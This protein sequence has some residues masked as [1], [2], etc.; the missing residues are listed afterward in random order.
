M[1]RSEL[2]LIYLPTSHLVSH[3]IDEAGSF[4]NE[5]MINLWDEMRYPWSYQEQS[6]QRGPDQLLDS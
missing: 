4:L 2:F 5:E 6:S 1:D 3:Q